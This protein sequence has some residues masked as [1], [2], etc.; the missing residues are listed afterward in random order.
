MNV[1]STSSVK[2]IACMF[3][4]IIQAHISILLKSPIRV[5]VL[6]GSGNVSEKDMSRIELMGRK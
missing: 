3:E 6:C 5:H 2:D 1:K 4:N